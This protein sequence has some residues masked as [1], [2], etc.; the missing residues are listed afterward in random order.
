ME[1][2][3]G[4][5]YPWGKIYRNVPV[6]NFLYGAM[7]NTTAT[8]F[9]DYYL[10]DEREAM[11]RDYVGTNAHELTHQWFGDFITE[12][13]GESHWL[14]ESFATHYAKQFKRSVSSEMTTNG[15][16]IWKCKVPLMP[17]VKMTFL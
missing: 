13:N 1:K 2:E 12:W 17:I 10:K 8:I 3:F 16:D 9:T 14:H 6:A 5:N 15:Q 11:E 7:E 4:I